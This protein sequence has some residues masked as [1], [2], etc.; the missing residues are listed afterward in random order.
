M[1]SLSLSLLCETAVALPAQALRPTGRQSAASL[2]E[3]NNNGLDDQTCTFSLFLII[4]IRIKI[5]YYDSLNGCGSLVQRAPHVQYRARP[6]AHGAV[7][8]RSC[9]RL[10]A[11]VGQGQDGGRLCI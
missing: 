11:L 4:L 2:L 9:V 1:L 6:T 10:V 3:D 8:I 7:G 5:Y